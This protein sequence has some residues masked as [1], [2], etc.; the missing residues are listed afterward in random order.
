MKRVAKYYDILIMED[1]PADIRLIEE[2]LS[3]VDEQINISV[4]MDGEEGLD[5]LYKRGKYS[6]VSSPD[7]IF[8]DL[9]MPKKEGKEVLRVVKNDDKL[10]VIPIIVL[11]N[12]YH[13]EEIREVYRLH[14][15]AY[16][17]KPLDFDDFREVIAT[18]V[19][20]WFSTAEIPPKPE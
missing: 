8:L 3:E 12:S 2:A 17:H 20:F 18:T 9:N 6:E 16:V 10:K 14:A 11:T 4:A 1:R 7:L 13:R 19:N 15:N 5:F